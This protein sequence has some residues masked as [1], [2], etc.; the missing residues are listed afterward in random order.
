LCVDLWLR[1]GLKQSCSALR[2]ISNGMCHATCTQR[3]QG[4]SKFLM[5]K[6]QIG[7]LTIWFLAFLLAL[8]FKYPNG[9]CKFILDIYVSRAFQW[10]NKLFNPM[11]FDPWNFFLKIGGSI[12]T[13]IPK[14]GARLGMW[15]FI[16]SHSPTLLGAWNVT[17]GF[18]SWPTLS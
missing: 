14:V 15:R 18:H 16:P 9:S 6:S 10:Y 12:G 5:V 17:P 1:W 7:K 8:C 3:N 4:D 2:D 11:G 13:L